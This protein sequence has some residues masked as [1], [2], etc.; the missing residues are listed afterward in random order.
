MTIQKFDYMVKGAENPVTNIIISAI[1]WEKGKQKDNYL[2]RTKFCTSSQLDDYI[3]RANAAWSSMC[4]LV[5][6]GTKDR[7]EFEVS[8][9][10]QEFSKWETVLPYIQLKCGKVYYR[11]SIPKD[12]EGMETL[13]SMFGDFHLV[14]DIK[15]IVKKWINGDNVVSITGDQQ[16]A[17]TAKADDMITQQETDLFVVSKGEIWS[18]DSGASVGEELCLKKRTYIFE[19]KRCDYKSS[20]LEFR[21]F[22]KGGIKVLIAELLKDEYDLENVEK[23][24]LRKVESLEI[25]W[26][27]KLEIL[28]RDGR[29]NLPDA[30]FDHIMEFLG[31]SE[32]K[33]QELCGEIQP[34][35]HYNSFGVQSEKSVK[36]VPLNVD[37]PAFSK[38]LSQNKVRD[39]KE[40]ED[41]VRSWNGKAV[42][43]WKLDGAAV[44]LHYKGQH[45]VRAESKG[46]ARDVT[47]LMRGISGVP[48]VVNHGFPFIEDWFK[49]KEWFVTGELVA[50]NGRRSVAAGYLLR[51]DASSDETAEIANRLQFVAYDSNICEYPSK[52]PMVSPIRLYSQMMNLLKTEAYFNVVELCEFKGAEQ[53]S[54]GYI[55]EELPPPQS[56]DTDGL[57]VRVNDIKKYASL[58]ETSHH[59]KGS[60]AFKFEDEWKRVR[61]DC[62][63]G[64]RGDNGVLKIIAEFRPLHFGDKTV[65]SAV[66]QPKDDGRYRLEYNS[67]LWDKGGGGSYE[68]WYTDYSAKDGKVKFTEHFN[69]GEIEVCLRGKV[70]PQWRLVTD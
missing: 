28:Y 65:K 69:V 25:D 24:E 23:V 36:S 41:I 6:K 29:S 64:K 4:E 27:K 32:E 18:V 70:I 52:D 13:K 33:I 39:E 30:V 40:L 2:V 37:Y 43:S 60:I 1:N 10:V 9:T 20:K 5:E 38:I 49:D 17:K 45:L 22:V 55:T 63:Y 62:I 44:R 68:V 15:A 48:E 21:F 42:V 16:T 50:I 34:S 67:S 56:F 12:A 58:G 53:I 59:P 8:T 51:K 66:W 26:L 14:P 47:E 11:I 19:Y 31:V 7:V 54:G 46:K 57:V 61:P 3:N 35:G